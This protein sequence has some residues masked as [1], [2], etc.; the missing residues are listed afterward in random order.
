MRIGFIGAG[1]VGFSLGRYLTEHEYTVTG[2]YSKSLASAEDAARFTETNKYETMKQLVEVSDV[3]FLTV[4]DGAIPVVW[5]RLK[6]ID[7]NN[8]I[9]C[10]TSGALGSEVF[11]GM[12]NQKVYG[13]SVHPILAISDK[14]ESYK[15]IQSAFFTIEG[16]SEK[17]DEVAGIFLKCKNRVQIIDASQ[18]IKYHAACSIVSNFAVT[19]ADMAGKMLLESGFDEKTLFEALG[20]LILGNAHNIVEK[21]TVEALTGPIER[22][23]IETVEKH[24]SVLRGDEL[25]LYKALAR[26]TLCLAK[27][28]NPNRNYNSMMEV[29]E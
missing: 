24:M 26:R 1:K 27:E 15:D 10:H 12:E 16:S 20:P 22:G 17:I 21:G 28:K 14:Y 23:D 9:I 5:E 6:E 4:P 13:F 29:L 11:S 7:L 2:Y 18:K 19:L 8:K 25:S 3:L